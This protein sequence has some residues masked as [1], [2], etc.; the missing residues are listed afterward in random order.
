MKKALTLLLS[1]ML[2][3]T[4][5]F[6]QEAMKAATTM[7]SVSGTA[8]DQKAQLL[9]KSLPFIKDAP[10]ILKVPMTYR[11]APLCNKGTKAVLENVTERS[12]RTQTSAVALTKPELLPEPMRSVA[13][14]PQCNREKALINFISIQVSDW[15][16]Q[17]PPSRR[18]QIVAVCSKV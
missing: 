12:S 7:S 3:A 15:L 4:V 5:V 6:A 10:K 16:R 1:G 14:C 17:L 11:L 18:E 13:G 2:C 9:A 8:V